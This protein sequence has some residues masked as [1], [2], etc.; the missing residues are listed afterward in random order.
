MAFA[1]KSQSDP[2]AIN[3]PALQL[4]KMTLK[5]VGDSPLIVHAWSEKAKRMILDKQQ[6]KA[7]NGKEVRRPAVEF[8]NSLYWLTEKPEVDNLSDEEAQK[9]LSEII[10][11]SKFGFPTKAFKAAAIDAGYQQDILDKKTT[12]RGAFFIEGEF[13]E[14]HGSP[15]IREDM[16]K[17]GMGTADLRYRAE[18][19]TWSTELL[20][21]FNARSM[22]AEQIVN[23]IN[24]GGFAN[25]VGEWRPARDGTYGRFHVA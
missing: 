9:V 14:I 15:I 3:I 4:Q 7:G 1:K 23:L 16:V 12:A 13:A 25:G 8:A 10:P 21:T 22:S 18:F 6:K 2:D 5:I 19:P 20:I 17:I 24:V 11:K